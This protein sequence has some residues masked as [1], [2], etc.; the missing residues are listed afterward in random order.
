MRLG[1]LLSHFYELLLTHDSPPRNDDTM[2]QEIVSGMLIDKKHECDGKNGHAEESLSAGLQRR[3]GQ[4]I[5]GFSWQSDW[6]QLL[7]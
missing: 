4:K 1:L 6:W 2:T 3:T 7:V 5:R